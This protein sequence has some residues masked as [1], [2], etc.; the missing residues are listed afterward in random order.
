MG[1]LTLELPDDLIE[2]IKSIPDYAEN[3]RKAL[4]NMAMEIKENKQIE[5]KSKK[6][7]WS[8]SPS[9]GMWKDR[10]DMEDPTAYVRNLRKPRY[11]N[12][13]K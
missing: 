10:E 5:K 12:I 2:K 6:K 3:S 9:F 7:K 1:T 11:E 13:L 4:K 8:E